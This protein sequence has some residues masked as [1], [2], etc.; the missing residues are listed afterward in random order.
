MSL[1]WKYLSIE[2]LK[3]LEIT[4]FVFGFRDS[5]NIGNNKNYDV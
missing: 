1:H 4:S 2:T 5:D 3:K